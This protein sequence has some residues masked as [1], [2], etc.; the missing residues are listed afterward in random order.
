MM[1]A[2]DRISCFW[3]GLAWAWWQGSARGLLIAVGFGWTLSILLLATFVWPNWFSPRIVALTW[4]ALLF[5]W[6][7]EI[8][9]SNWTLRKLKTH[10][11]PINN[12]QRF[13]RAQ[14]EYL[15]GNWFEAESLLHELLRDAPRDAEA[16]LLLVGVLRHCRRWNA[17]QRKLEQLETLDTA[18]RWRFEIQRERQ[19]LEKRRAATAASETDQETSLPQPASE[20]PL[21]P[22]DAA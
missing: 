21:D 17:A 14:E 3:P 18:A 5:F 2:P 9:R 19:L 12:D 22:L 7:V 4:V 6:V 10:G 20:Q 16:H 8:V 15:R 1:L 13:A 11:L